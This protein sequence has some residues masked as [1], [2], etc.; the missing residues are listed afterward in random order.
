MLLREFVIDGYTIRLN[1]DSGLYIAMIVDSSGEKLFYQE[2]DDYE[3]VKE[4]FDIIAK[5]YE[6]SNTNIKRVLEILESSR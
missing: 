4:Y 2:Y 5:E 3:K 1:E 6:D